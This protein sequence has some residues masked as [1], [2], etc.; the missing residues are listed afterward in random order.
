MRWIWVIAAGAYFYAKAQ[1][2]CNS[3]HVITSLPFIQT[4]L[5]TCGTGDDYSNV[6]A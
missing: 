3:P 5:T 1:N 6:D 2:T 4:G